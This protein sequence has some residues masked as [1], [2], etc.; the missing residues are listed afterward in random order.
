M[1]KTAANDFTFEE[2]EA[3]FKEEEQETP[4]VVTSE[5]PPVT[6]PP[7]Q[8]ISGKEGAK[9]VA[10]RINAER[11]AIAEKM[12]YTSYE[13]MLKIQQEKIEIEKKNKEEELI[14]NKGLNP[15]DV[16]SIYEELLK[17]DPRM[18]ELESFRKK[19]VEEYGLKQL[20]EITKLTDGAITKLEQLPKNVVDL[21]TKNGDLKAAYLQLEGEKLI[22]QARSAQ[23]KG[24]TQHMQNPG[25]QNPPPLTM[26]A[27][28]SDERAV[29]KQ[30]HP[31]ITEE[32]L[33]KKTMPI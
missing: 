24:T 7:T 18:K 11:K 15:T 4:P 1:D 13:E 9:I 10:E 14:K 17:D 28:T 20:A 32:E 25:G 21:W 5:T 12:G 19:Q 30:F 2:L 26:R 31:N 33:N 23:S 22:A 29:W 6:E 3:L 8:K 27:L 16:K